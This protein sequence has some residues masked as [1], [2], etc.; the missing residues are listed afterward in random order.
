MG[1]QTLLWFAVIALFTAKNVTATELPKRLSFQTLDAETAT[2][3]N[4]LIYRNGELSGQYRNLLDCVGSKLHI[5]IT[6]VGKPFARAQRNL[7]ANKIDGFFPA[8]ITAKRNTYA[9]PSAPLFDDRKILIQ[10]LNFQQTSNRPENIESHIGV[11]RGAELEQALATNLNHST[12]L[13]GSY[14]QLIKM[15]NTGHIGAVLTSEMFINSALS[16]TPLSV[17]T[18]RLE[19]ESAPMHLYFNETLI[20]NYP[21][22]LSSFNNALDECRPLHLP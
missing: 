14:D 21:S 22:L 11:M 8:N 13:V 10:S 2:F 1:N 19:L 15:L 9:V 18:T 17:P 7:K 16:K 5:P 3:P 12:T 4:L 20:K 6:Y